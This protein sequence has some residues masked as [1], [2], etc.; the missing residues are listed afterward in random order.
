MKIAVFHRL[1][2]EDTALRLNEEAKNLGIELVW[3]KYDQLR[4]DGDQIYFGKVNLNGFDGWYFRAVGSE[5]EWSKLLQLYAKK[6][7]IRVVDDYLM[8]E[9]PLRRFKSV[10]GWQFK[11]AEINYP[12]TSYV[13]RMEDLELDLKDRKFPLIIKLSQGGRH[14][15]GTFFLKNSSELNDLKERLEKRNLKAKELGKMER[16]YRGFLVQ[17]YIPNDGDIRVMTVGYKCVGGFKRQAKVEKLVLNMSEGKSVGLDK[18]PA[19]IKKEAEKAAK[20][21]GVEIAG[22]DMIRDSRNG[23]VYVVEVN[24]APQ[25]KVFEKRTGVNVAKTILEY[26][27]KKFEK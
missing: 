1:D 14:G 3:I 20:V 9:G 18:I 17:E 15:M 22:T 11:D 21:L 6:H 12:D 4:L 24:E 10:M 27:V 16:N 19:D 2:F 7:K 13:E 26:L 23:K 25:F 5:L 8:K